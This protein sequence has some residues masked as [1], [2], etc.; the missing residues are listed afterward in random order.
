MTRLSYEYPKHLSF[1]CNR[2]TL[3]CHDSKYRVRSILLLRKEAARISEI[4]QLSLSEFAERTE[5]HEPYLYRMRKTKDGKCIFLKDDSCSI[6]QIRPLIC[7][8]YPFELKDLTDNRYA[9]SYSNE[10]PAIGKGSSLGKEFFKQRFKEFMK[11][12]VENAKML[13]PTKIMLPELGILELGFNGII[14]KAKGYVF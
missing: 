3:C 1:T 2:C 4:I 10:C 6:Y 11:S 12:M 14:S 5:D 9:F 8:F 7:R 13:N